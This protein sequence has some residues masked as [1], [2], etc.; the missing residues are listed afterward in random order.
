MTFVGIPVYIRF[1]IGHSRPGLDIS[2]IGEDFHTRN[3]QFLFVIHIVLQFN[4]LWATS[5]LIPGER[6]Y[7]NSHETFV[8]TSYV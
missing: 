2:D 7:G 1:G 3:L 5:N 4:A 6:E 8:V